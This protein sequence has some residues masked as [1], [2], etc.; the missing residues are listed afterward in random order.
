MGALAHIAMRQLFDKRSD[1]LEN[2]GW[3]ATEMLFKVA[4]VLSI[5]QLFIIAVALR[6]NNSHDNFFS[7]IKMLPFL[8]PTTFC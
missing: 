6:N 3:A 8:F 1:T 5:W 4:S 2:I 7:Y